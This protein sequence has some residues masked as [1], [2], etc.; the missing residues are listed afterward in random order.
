MLASSLPDGPALLAL[1]AEVRRSGTDLGAADLHG[2]W[3][4]DQVWPKGSRRPASFSALLLR[5]LAARLEI[6]PGGGAQP[7]GLT[8]SNAVNLGPVELRFRGPGRLQGRRPLLMFQFD[9]LEL[10][11]AGRLLL[12]RALLAP[13]PHRQPFFALIARGAVSAETGPAAAWLAARG[14]GG[15]LALWRLATPRP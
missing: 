11:L 8:L 1:E 14:R 7:Q 4:L 15:G 13:A 6:G 3:Q 5:G 2:C 10:R 9:Q 12:Q